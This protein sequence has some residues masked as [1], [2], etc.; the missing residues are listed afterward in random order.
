MKN[1]VIAV[2]VVAVI[3]LLAINFHAPKTKAMPMPVTTGYYQYPA[4]TG[5]HIGPQPPRA[6]I[7]PLAPDKA[8]LK[9]VLQTSIGPVGGIPHAG[10]DPLAPNKDEVA[11]IL[12]DS[13]K[14][15]AADQKEAGDW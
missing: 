13:T 3:A 12:H 2:L 14:S 4:V 15:K 7:D 10:I 8:E 11:K 9:K 1:A 5:I 6:G